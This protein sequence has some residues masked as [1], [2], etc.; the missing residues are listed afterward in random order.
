V[1][2]APPGP[3]AVS[4]YLLTGI[5]PNMPS[6]RIAIRYGIRGYTSSVGTACASGAQSI[7]DGCG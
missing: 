5:L 6:A 2:A 7:A 3:G 1:L 4:P